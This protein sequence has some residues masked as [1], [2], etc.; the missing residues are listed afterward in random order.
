[1]AAGLAHEIRNP[2]A[3]LSGS[4]QLLQ[5]ERQDPLYDIMLREVQR[6]NGLVEDFLD[7]ARPA[8][9]RPE[10][11]EPAPVVDELLLT[12]RN[13]P[14]FRDRALGRAPAE[15]PVAPAWL[16]PARFRQLLWNLL[17]NAAQATRAGGTV[18]V[19]LRDEGADLVVSVRD[20]G[21]GVSPELLPRIF[22][23]FF[24]NKVGGTGLGLANVERLTRAH[25][26][27]VEVRSGVGEGTCFTLRFPRPAAR[28]GPSGA[29]PAPPLRGA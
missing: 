25:G 19:E 6:L 5:T 3:S 23:P 11:V 26:G 12:L 21:V 28:G 29:P 13:D 7:S 9:V 1:M 8:G 15:P 16:D 10:W 18:S 2:L 24:T 22:D 27:G 14:R 4:V 17:L 20:D